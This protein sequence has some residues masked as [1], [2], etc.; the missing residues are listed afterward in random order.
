MKILSYWGYFKNKHSSKHIKYNRSYVTLYH[1]NVKC[2]LR[3][4][5]LFMSLPNILSILFYV[6]YAWARQCK[7]MCIEGQMCGYLHVHVFTHVEARRQPLVQA[8][9]FVV[10]A[11]EPFTGLELAK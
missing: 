7:I 4:L 9:V 3:F 1:I 8:T 2:R 5:K 6:R 11:S 10:S